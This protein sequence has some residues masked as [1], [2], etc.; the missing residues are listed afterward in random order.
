MKQLNQLTV[1]G[2]DQ[3]YGNMKTANTLFPTAIT[4]FD[5]A[6]VFQGDVLEY[7]GR[8]YRVGEGHKGFVADK[9]SDED[10]YLLTLAAVA[11]ELELYRLFTANLCLAVGLP[12]SW[13]G[14][15]RE[16]FRQYLLQKQ[17]VTFRLNGHLFQLR[18][19]GCKV[20][21][22]GYA[23]V[24]QQLGAFEGEHLL[25]DIGNGTMNLLYLQDS[26]P[27][28]SRC[29]TE[30]IGV[31][32]C[33]IR[34]KETVLRKFGTKISDHTVEQIL[35]TGTAKIDAAYLSCIRDVASAY[36]EELF[37]VLR[38]YEYDPATV[39]LIVA[40]GG[41][42]LIKHFYSYDPAQITILDDLCAAAKGYEYLAYRQLMREA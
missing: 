30:K 42:Q 38:S 10:F 1:V 7:D 5:T 4:A 17:A 24:V 14:S 40:G 29:W 2:I 20:Y 13:V 21:P 32:Q 28:E 25:A 37:A 22:Q 11:K 34:A 23:A 27:Q 36:V 35:R 12:L 9:S 3:G 16:S 31:N 19:T 15:Q 41:G 6:P 33:M 26:Q 8:F 18:I 39:Q